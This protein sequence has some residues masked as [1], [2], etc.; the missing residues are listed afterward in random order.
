MKRM[1]TN[2]TREKTIIILICLIG[3]VF[4]A[5]F[6][7]AELAREEATIFSMSIN[8]NMI[9]LTSNEKFN[10]I[11]KERIYKT[12]V[13]ISSLIIGSTIDEFKIP[14]VQ[15]YERLKD[16]V[17]SVGILDPYSIKLFKEVVSLDDSGMLAATYEKLKDRVRSLGI[18]DPYYIELFKEVV[19]L[20]EN[21]AP[22]RTLKNKPTNNIPDNIVT[23]NYT[24]DDVYWLSVG[25]TMEVG[26]SWIPEYIRNYV[27]CVILNRVDS[28][29]FPGTTIYDI[30][31]QP[32]QYPWAKTGHLE[33]YEW[34]VET[35]R[36]LLNGNRM[37]PNDI[38][39]QAEFPQGN[40]TYETYYDE[41]LKT[42]TYFCANR[43]E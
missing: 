40:F 26:C 23:T 41:H 27:G 18:L 19:A 4:L 39:F 36:D 38:I 3:V 31:H 28:S 10:N 30:L 25:I 33:P 13:E 24:E 22:L 42:T 2:F 21:T 29:L 32:G 9:G 7:K 35:A 15:S 17:R 16:R 43:N 14:T 1:R 37:L 34:C 5:S 8:D 6:K 11:M 20:E 12:D